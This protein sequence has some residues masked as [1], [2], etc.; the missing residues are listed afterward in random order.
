MPDVAISGI[1]P[2]YA[3]RSADETELMC[4][5]E[6]EMSP[7]QSGAPRFESTPGAEG[8][9]SGGSEALV[10]RFSGSGAGGSPG[11][12]GALS[13]PNDALAC[14]PQALS[15]AG[16]CLRLPNVIATGSP[17]DIIAASLQCAAALEAFTECLIEP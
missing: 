16:S 1:Q 6:P 11:S 7:A 3:Q 4:L 14:V 8:A 13:A 15:A 10:Q 2:N 9:G 5:G 17:G 12:P